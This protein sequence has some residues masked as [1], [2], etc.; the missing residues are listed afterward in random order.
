MATMRVGML[1]SMNASVHQPVAPPVDARQFLRRQ[2]QH[3]HARVDAFFVDGLQSAGDYARYL[4][5]MHRFAADHEI[6]VGT[7]PRQSF[8]LACDLQTLGLAPL[9]PGGV[10]TP[11]ANADERLGWEYV[12]AGSS[13]GARYLLRHA[14]ALGHDEAAG[15]RFLTRHA[16]DGG[17]AR[18]LE[19]LAACAPEDGALM[20]RLQRGACDAFVQVQGCFERSF[21]THPAAAQESAA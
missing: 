6:A 2:T 19:R 20:A 7:L 13:V 5:G 17:W 12:M 4:V 18:V 14:L 16:A 10:C 1:F 3:L 8:W 9:P 21:H 15:A 11:V